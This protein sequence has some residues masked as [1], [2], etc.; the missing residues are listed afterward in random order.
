[1]IKVKNLSYSINSTSII[2]DISL[3]IKDGEY[4]CILGNNGCGKTTFLRLLSSLIFPSSGDIFIDGIS[5]K[6]NTMI[7][8]NRL[9]TSLTF[10]NVDFSLIGE[11]LNEDVSFPLKN[12]GLNKD[13]V[14]ERVISTLSFFDLLDKREE[15]TIKL[16]LFEKKKLSLATCI[17]TKPKY[18]LLDEIESGLSKEESIYINRKLDILN[19]EGMSIVR[20]THDSSLLNNEKRYIYFSK[21]SLN[22]DKLSYKDR[23]IKRLQEG[24]LKMDEISSLLGE[25]YEK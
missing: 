17:T 5:T 18:L 9:L 14:E 1:M 21:F 25:I 10:Q 7:Y 22:G 11:N 19:K 15:K 20:V 24:G 12:I 8:R 6:D 3:E 4:L 16:S 13:E 23:F 2:K